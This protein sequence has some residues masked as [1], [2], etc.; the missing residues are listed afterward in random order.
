MKLLTYAGGVAW[1]VVICSGVAACSG[2]ETPP[3]EPAFCGGFA[4]IPCPQGQSCIDDPND[5]CD[6][7]AGGADCGGIC[8]DR[9]G[10]TFCGG[11]AGFPCPSGE[12]CVDDPSDSC[13]PRTGGADCG[14]M[15][16]KAE[17]CGDAQCAPGFVCCN[18]VM[19]IC[20]K[21]GMVCIQ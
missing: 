20:T 17:T 10:P 1:S 13:D 15:C 18:P 19:G 12:T 21:P 5:G 11:I 9:P 6:P 8:V 3:P 7:N 4:G 14:G 16:V 2:A